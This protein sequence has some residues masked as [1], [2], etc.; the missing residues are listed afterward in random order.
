MH[1]STNGTMIYWC[2]WWFLFLPPS[3]LSQ[4]KLFV[5]APSRCLRRRRNVQMPQMHR[6][7]IIPPALL[8]SITLHLHRGVIENQ[9]WNRICSYGITS[10]NRDFMSF[11][12]CFGA[13][14]AQKL[15]YFYSHK[16]TRARNDSSRCAVGVDS[17]KNTPGPVQQP[18]VSGF[19]SDLVSHLSSVERL[20]KLL[21]LGESAAEASNC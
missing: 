10:H 21:H 5:R 16:T 4:L 1:C 19:Y 20:L 9:L 15:N 8:R 12:L 18:R 3:F 11:S 2:F 6:W 7:K 14:S 13:N 17:Y